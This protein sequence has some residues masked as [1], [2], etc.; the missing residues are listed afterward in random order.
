MSKLVKKKNFDKR[1][2]IMIV[3]ILLLVILLVG[4]LTYCSKYIY[5][6]FFQDEVQSVIEHEYPVVLT[7]QDLRFVSGLDK[8]SNLH[9]MYKC[10]NKCFSDDIDNLRIHIKAPSVG[11]DG[12]SDNYRVNDICVKIWNNEMFEAGFNLAAEDDF[13]YF[14]PARGMSVVLVWWYP[15]TSD[16]NH[17]AGDPIPKDIEITIYKRP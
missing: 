5:N 1:K 9:F 12:V 13:M 17:H 8:E 14:V 11:I 4:F 7:Y 2:I 15:Y 6:Y 10:Y 3:I 16:G